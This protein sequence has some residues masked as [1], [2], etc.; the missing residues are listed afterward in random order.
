MLV[1]DNRELFS[2]VEVNSRETREEKSSG[3][4]FGDNEKALLDKTGIVLAV[5][6]LK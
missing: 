4:V 5:L 6:P 1:L 2:I 3:K